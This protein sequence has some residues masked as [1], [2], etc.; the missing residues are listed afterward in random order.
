MHC[1]VRRTFYS[2]QSVVETVSGQHRLAIDLA[3]TTMLLPI[4]IVPFVLEQLRKT[5]SRSVRNEDD[6]ARELQSSQAPAPVR[7]AL[8]G[9]LRTPNTVARH[10]RPTLSPRG[11]SCTTS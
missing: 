8:P 9:P 4:G 6:M 2:R 1:T 10:C 11:R 3:V 7:P 5:G